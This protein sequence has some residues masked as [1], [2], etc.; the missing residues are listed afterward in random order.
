[1]DFLC[2]FGIYNTWKT[3]LKILIV[4]LNIDKVEIVYNLQKKIIANE[5]LHASFL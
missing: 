1:M 3:I 2:L 5:I 4:I